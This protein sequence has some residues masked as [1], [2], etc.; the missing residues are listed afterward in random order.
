MEVV[1]NL[2]I[3]VIENIEID[4]LK[5]N[6]DLQDIAKTIGIE[7]VRKLIELHSGSSVYIPTYL[8]F[9]SALRK[10]VLSDKVKAMSLKDKAYHIGIG[11]RTLSKK[12]KDWGL[13]YFNRL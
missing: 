3:E 5:S 12:M 2:R 8:V 9:D 1:L 11:K 6:K 13:N 4:D 10:V 7:N